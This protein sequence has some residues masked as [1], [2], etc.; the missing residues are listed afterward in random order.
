M[1]F[2]SVNWFENKVNQF[3]AARTPRGSR[4]RSRAGRPTSSP[5]SPA[6]YSMVFANRAQLASAQTGAGLLEIRAPR[7]ATVQAA[8]KRYG[9]KLAGSKPFKL[10][11]DP[12]ER[13]LANPLLLTQG[14]YD[15]VW[16][17]DSDDPSGCCSTERSI[18]SKSWM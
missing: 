12:R 4:T 15:V 11:A 2:R 8:I 7:S 14:T 16:V 5:R 3:T 10:S 6:T 1:L 13:D 18:A 9:L 17:I